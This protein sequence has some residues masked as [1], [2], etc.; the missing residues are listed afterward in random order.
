LIAAPPMSTGISMPRRSSSC[1][2]SGICLLVETS[3]AE[4]P[5]AS[6]FTSTAF[7]RI[8]FTGTCLPR[9]TTV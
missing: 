6:A 2:Q 4:S 9:S 7:S 5:I 8:V 3:S 1:T